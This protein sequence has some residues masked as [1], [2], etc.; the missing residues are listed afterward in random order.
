MKKTRECSDDDTRWWGQD[1]TTVI[2]RP[3]NNNNETTQQLRQR[4]RWWGK[5]KESDDKGTSI[6]GT[7]IQSMDES[8]SEEN[9]CGPHEK[10]WQPQWFL[11]IIIKQCFHDCFYKTFIVV[12]P[13]I[14]K[15]ATRFSSMT[16]SGNRHWLSVIKATFCSSEYNRS[17][18]P[19]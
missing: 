12:N 16:I 13:L 3:C 6:R 19:L 15:I 8:V 18:V 9:K 5:P 2:A 4:W 11:K 1:Q 17:I 10:D 7:R 14:Y